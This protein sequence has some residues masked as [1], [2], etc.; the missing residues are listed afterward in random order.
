MAAITG[1]PAGASAPSDP[2]PFLLRL[3]PSRWRARYGD[4]FLELLEARP[5]SLR[6]RVDIVVGAVDARVNPQVEGASDREVRAP[7][8]RS[9]RRLA[10]ATG[11]LLTVWG[12]VGAMYMRPWN[13][14][15]WPYDQTL[16]TIGWIV[17]MAGAISAMWALALIATTYTRALGSAGVGGALFAGVGLILASLGAGVLAL[18]L[19]AVGTAL[20]TW[21]LR[22]PM[23]DTPTALVFLAATFALVGGWV[24]FAAGGGQDVRLLLGM[25]GYG[26]AWLLFGL[27]LRAPSVPAIIGA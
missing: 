27:R 12:S 4:E 25:Y 10:V 13:S 24:A 26:P 18:L 14:G 2:M 21:R 1:R 15:D 19:I 11:A 16:T 17:G 20:L 3:Y 6:D 23:L 9:I 5:P 8:D 7:G 22:G